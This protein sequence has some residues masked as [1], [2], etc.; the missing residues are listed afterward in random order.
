MPAG[1]T[2]ARRPRV[3]RIKGE[4]VPTWWPSNGEAVQSYTAAKGRHDLWEFRLG[5]YKA[6]AEPEYAEIGGPLLNSDPHTPNPKWIERQREMVFHSYA[7]DGYALVGL[8]DPWGWKH[9]Q[10]GDIDY[11]DAP[12][13]EV[14]AFGHTWTPWM[15][16]WV[17][18]IAD[19]FTCIGSV[20][21]DLG[22][23]AEQVDNYDPNF[24]RQ[25]LASWRAAEQRHLCTL[26]DGTKVPFVHMVGTSV[27]ELFGVVDFVI[28]HFDGPLTAPIADRWTLSNEHGRDVSP[29]EDQQRFKLARDQGLAYGLWRGGLSD[30]DLEDT[31]ARRKAV[32][33]GTLPSV[34]PM[35]LPAGAVVY[36]NDN[37]YGQL[38]DEGGI[39]ILGVDSS[40][41]V[42]GSYEYCAALGHATPS[43]DCNLEP[44]PNRAA[45]EMELA[46]GCPVWD[47]YNDLHPG[48][49]PCEQVQPD[50][51]GMS[52]DHFGNT[53]FRDDPETPDIFE[54]RP[55]ECGYQRDELGN[56]MAG[57]WTQPHGGLNGY[58][59]ACLP[60]RST[61]ARWI[62]PIDH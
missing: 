23:E 3:F 14:A 32:V 34:C 33:D 61:C 21:I 18:T 8:F 11:I 43:N 57:F 17:D 10:W 22:N 52:C 27:P 36:I 7:L 13:A 6:L 44:W 15:E 42:R 5:P 48:A 25:M 50:E 39:H 51:S 2:R 37:P 45:C 47:W 30:A 31:L 58:A 56:P 41:R 1:S 62:G 16:A 4:E 53:E 59:R 40:I 20:M 38:V 29:A 35:P 24:Y 9:Q 19:N 55:A 46:G 60:D 54:G 28:T 12:A 26:P 49:Y